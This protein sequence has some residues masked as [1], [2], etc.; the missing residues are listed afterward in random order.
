MFDLK[1]INEDDQDLLEYLNTNIIINKELY[2]ETI[3]LKSQIDDVCFSKWKII[4]SISTDYE[5]IGNN[6]IHNYEKIKRYDII[7]RAYYKL[8]EILFKYKLR[9]NFDKK[10]Q[11]KIACLAEAP[12]GFIQCMIHYR[13]KFHNDEITTISLYQNEKNIEWGLKNNKYK[14]IYGDKKQ[15][16]DGNLYN[17]NIIEYFINSHKSKLDLVTADGGLLLIDFKENYKSQYHLQLFLSE[18]YISVKLLKTDGVFILKI[19][20]ISSKS[21]LDFMILV[22]NL[23]NYVSI[24]KP[25]TSRDMNNEKYIICRGL[26]KDT[27]EIQGEI[28]KIIKFLWENPKKLIN[29]I[30]KYNSINDYQYVLNIIIKKEKYNLYTQKNK[31]TNALVMKDDTVDELKK[32]LNLKKSFHLNNAYKWFY[33]NGININ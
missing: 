17:P 29:N 33:A 6:R 24:Y 16:H 1:Y 26:K 30:L 5:M 10:K 18:L 12:G 31:L 8:W 2:F 9:F 3:K 14:I 20:E 19:Y 21:M 28:F 27:D 22:N 15:K 25:K 11:M 32:K 7:S 13:Y 23:Y 4:R